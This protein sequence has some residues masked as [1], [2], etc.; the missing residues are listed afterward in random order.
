M[1][2]IETVSIVIPCRNEEN[3]I[4]KCLESI[5]QNDYPKEKLTVYVC[6]GKSNDRTL[7]IIA[8]IS[9]SHPFIKVLNN[10]KQTTPYA[11]NLGIKADNSDMSIIL[12][13]HSEIEK[14]YITNCVKILNEYPEVGCAGG[15][16][17]FIP[18][19]FKT[20]IVGMAMSSSFGVGN[21]YHKTGTKEGYV[22]TV[23]FGGYR[24]EVFS[25]IGYFDES[26]TRNQD[27]EFNYRV[28]KAGFKIYLSKEIKAKYYARSSF[29]SLYKQYFQYG[30]WKVYVNKK[31]AT[32]TTVR[33]VVPLLFVLFL[34]S[35]I[36]GS[37]FSIIIFKLFTF[38]LALY[39]LLAITAAAKKTKNLSNIFLV[40]YTFLILHISY[41]YGY[42]KGIIHFMLFNLEPK[43]K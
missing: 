42:L 43:Y 12:G 15:I 13:A 34:I 27:D 26:L 10:E 31:H 16:V 37:L 19:T 35:G 2:L 24:R 30:Y 29:K 14:D 22:D 5:I 38:I 25:K 40:V 7:E 32:I 36:L 6:D 17:S 4:H 23:A 41:G 28:L 3:Y 1:D 18:E 20:E 8:K 21:V 39:F 9:E 11:L 33:Q